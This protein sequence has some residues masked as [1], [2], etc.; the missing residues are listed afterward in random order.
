MKI[1]FSILF[2]FLISILYFAQSISGKI[3]GE[4]GEAISYVEII[5]KRDS[6]KK[7]TISDEK[8]VLV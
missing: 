1:R 5:V 6:I 3:I 8:E 4:N 7:A 2:F